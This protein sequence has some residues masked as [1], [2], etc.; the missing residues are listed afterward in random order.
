MGVHNQ[1]ADQGAGTENSDMGS[2]LSVEA[3]TLRP[4]TRTRIADFFRRQKLGNQFVDLVQ[5]VAPRI[6]GQKPIMGAPAEREFVC[7]FI[8]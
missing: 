4:P 7:C 5:A 3:M 8:L 2:G 1:L 6:A